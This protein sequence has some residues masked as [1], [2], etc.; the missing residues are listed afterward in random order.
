MYM[1]EKNVKSQIH[2]F[3][4]VKKKNFPYFLNVVPHDNK[5]LRKELLGVFQ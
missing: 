2:L 4:N 1:P 5:L 3:S